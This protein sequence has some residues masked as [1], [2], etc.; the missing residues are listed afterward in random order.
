MK[1]LLAIVILAGVSH[2]QVAP[3]KIDYSQYGSLSRQ[4]TVYNHVRNTLDAQ[5]ARRQKDRRRAERKRLAARLRLLRD[6]QR[7]SDR[8][9]HDT[10]S[11]IV[12]VRITGR[13]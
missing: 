12:T 9:R 2:A 1:T 11:R 5:E 8:Y 10:G 6:Y 7:Y 3:P 4:M 13:L